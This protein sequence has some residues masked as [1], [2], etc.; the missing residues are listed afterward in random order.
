MDVNNGIHTVQWINQL[1]LCLVNQIDDT[2]G[3]LL[4]DAV[5]AYIEGSFIQVADILGA[6]FK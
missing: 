5:I 2:Y 4:S 1:K 6:Q 3:A